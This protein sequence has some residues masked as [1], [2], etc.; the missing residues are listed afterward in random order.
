MCVYDVYLDLDFNLHRAD[1][2]LISSPLPSSF[3]GLKVG[4]RNIRAYRF[5]LPLREH[6]THSNRTSPGSSPP[7]VPSYT[8]HA[9]SSLEKSFQKYSSSHKPSSTSKHHGPHGLFCPSVVLLYR[10]PTTPPTHD[11]TIVN[12]GCLH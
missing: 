3:L 11:D 10:P 9:I 7:H 8:H 6:T 5:T 4:P 12:T 2:K 1:E